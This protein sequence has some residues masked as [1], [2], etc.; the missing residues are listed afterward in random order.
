ML[1][2]C[3]LEILLEKMC[4]QYPQLGLRLSGKGLTGGDVRSIK[5]PD[6]QMVFQY[7]LGKAISGPSSP[8]PW[9]LDLYSA[10]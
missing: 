2:S 1:S 7:L 5:P 8:L 4:K 10:A 3:N 9:G 6:Q